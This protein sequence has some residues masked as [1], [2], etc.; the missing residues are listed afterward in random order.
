MIYFSDFTWQ[1]TLEPP[2]VLFTSQLNT[3]SYPIYIY[4]SSINTNFACP[5]YKRHK[6]KVTTLEWKEKPK[7]LKN[8]FQ[9]KAL[10]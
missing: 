3:L 8:I 4:L 5:Y 10:T 6:M 1:V 2:S 9:E 7:S